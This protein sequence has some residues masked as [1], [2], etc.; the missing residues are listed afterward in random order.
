M[1]SGIMALLATGRRR[2]QDPGRPRHE[3]RRCAGDR[4][5]IGDDLEFVTHSPQPFFSACPPN[6]ERIAERI[7]SVNSPAC[8]DSKRS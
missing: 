6:S 2:E 5:G 7:L 8:L 3:R 4:V 1:G